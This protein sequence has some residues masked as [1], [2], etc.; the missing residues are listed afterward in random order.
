MY[1]IQYFANDITLF[2]SIVHDLHISPLAQ[3]QTTH[4]IQNF[5]SHIQVTSIQTTFFY[6]R[7][8]SNS[9]KSFQ[10]LPLNSTNNWKPTFSFNILSTL[11]YFLS[12][13]T[14]WNST[15]PDL[16]VIQTPFHFQF[17]STSF[18]ALLFL[19][20]T[21]YRQCTG[22]SWQNSFLSALWCTLNLPHSL[23]LLI[24][25]HFITR[26][27]YHTWTIVSYWGWGLY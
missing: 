8:S 9:A 27:V 13:L 15:R 6:S 11:D 23:T 5:L 1:D 16:Y 26:F 7:S 4:T 2:L 25:P 22:I 10:C 12:R 14:V 18:I 3:N 17:I 24:S 19:L 21:W 20:Y